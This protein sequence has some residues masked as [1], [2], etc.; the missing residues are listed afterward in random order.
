MRIE[1][2]AHKWYPVYSFRRLEEDED[3]DPSTDFGAEAA[4]DEDTIVKWEKVFKDFNNLQ[5]TLARL[6]K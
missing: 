1:I 4:T 6:H 2:D 5:N 3:A